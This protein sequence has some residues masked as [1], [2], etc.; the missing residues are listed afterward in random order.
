M[1]KK[2]H[3]ARTW[4]NYDSYMILTEEER[5]HLGEPPADP[6]TAADDAL[7]SITSGCGGDKTPSTI[8]ALTNGEILYLN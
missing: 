2:I 7:N 6:E 3:V 5:V 1:K 4:R 8:C